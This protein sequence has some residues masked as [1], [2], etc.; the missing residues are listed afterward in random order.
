MPTIH[1]TIEEQTAQDAFLRMLIDAIEDCN[2]YY[3]LWLN[4]EYIKERKR[5]VRLM[6]LDI[7]GSVVMLDY[8]VMRIRQYLF[9]VHKLETYYRQAEAK[10]LSESEAFK[11]KEE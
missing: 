1:I 4:D 10:D 9:Q 5:Y 2:L 8:L 11:F 7:S 6:Y 3:V